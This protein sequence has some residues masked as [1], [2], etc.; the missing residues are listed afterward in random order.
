MRH[1]LFALMLVSGI[2]CQEK[3]AT[4]APSAAAPA[5]QPAAAPAAVAPSRPTG[6][7][8]LVCD[9]DRFQKWLA[10]KKEA[11]A[12]LAGGLQATAQQ[13][14]ANKNAPTQAATGLGGLAA[15]GNALMAVEQKHGFAKGEAG[16]YD[17]LANAT[18]SARPLDN[19]MMKEMVESMR[20]M[21]TQGGPSKASADEFFQKQ[22]AD[23]KKAEARARQKFGDACVDVFMKHGAEINETQMASIAAVLGGP[24]KTK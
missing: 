16:R 6:Q 23:G 17:A 22:E 15:T 21:Q 5:A 13:V 2:G 4:P 11:T 18:S 24:K 14:E 8:Q 12:V 3:G 9:E 20:K 1:A 10:Y 7:E 19:P